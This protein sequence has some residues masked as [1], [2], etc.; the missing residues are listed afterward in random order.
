[1]IKMTSRRDVLAAGGAGLL[2]APA[3]AT[4]SGPD[5]DTAIAVENIA[6][7]SGE[8]NAAL[9]RGDLQTYRSLITYA[10]DFTFMS[11]FGGAPK[12]RADFTDARMLDMSRSFK[13]GVFQQEVVESYAAG[14]LVVL[15]LIEQQ[16]VEVGG[17]PAQDWRLRVTLV[18]RRDGAGWQLAHRHADPLLN[19][20][21]LDEAARLAR[22]DVQL[23]D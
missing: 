3:K 10:A 13:N 7:L 2:G 18:Y 21:G 19:A 6:R 1:M 8:A 15:V 4:Q 9:M 5:V 14:D 20:I 16:R 22:G 23:P 17:L 11:P 12:R